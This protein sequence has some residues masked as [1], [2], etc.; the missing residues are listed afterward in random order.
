MSAAKDYRLPESRCPK[1]DYKLN[2]AS[3]VSGE[4]VAPQP[5]DFSIC[6]NCGQLLVYIDGTLLRKATAVE[7]RRLMDEPEQWAVIEKAQAFIQ[8]RG[9][10]A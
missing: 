5:G 4:D 3:I 8:Q 7:I 9:R 6:L 10:Y 2:G 1:C